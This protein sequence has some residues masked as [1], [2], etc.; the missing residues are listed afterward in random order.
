VGIVMLDRKRDFSFHVNFAA[1]FPVIFCV[2]TDGRMRE[3][4]YGGTVRKHIIHGVRVSRY[5]LP[6]SV[7]P[8]AGINKDCDQNGCRHTGKYPPQA[9]G[10]P[11]LFRYLV[12][13]FES[14]Q[15][16][17]R[18]QLVLLIVAQDKMKAF[19]I[20]GS[21]TLLFWFSY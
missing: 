14:L 11:F 3:Q 2:E 13:L 10:F 16:F 7:F 12:F 21:H 4:G 6:C 8:E 20:R 19:F 5:L 9:E 17:L 15:C 1:G 18:I